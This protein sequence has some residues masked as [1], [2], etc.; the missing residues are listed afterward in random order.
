MLVAYIASINQRVNLSLV[1]QLGEL[2]SEF[3]TYKVPTQRA[4]VATVEMMFK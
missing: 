3:R 4:L 2:D 1:P